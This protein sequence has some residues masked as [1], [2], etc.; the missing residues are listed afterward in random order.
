MNIT[1]RAIKDILNSLSIKENIFVIFGEDHVAISVFIKK[2][3]ELELISEKNLLEIIHN[4]II[5]VGFKCYYQHIDNQE[6]T[7]PNRVLS[8]Q[9]LAYILKNKEL[10]PK[11]KQHIKYSPMENE[12][13]F[14][15][16]Y[17]P[18][19]F[20]QELMD[21]LLIVRSKGCAELCPHSDTCY[22][23]NNC[24]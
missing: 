2:A 1:T 14:V 23:A 4:R 12:E 8:P 16:T 9:A 10:E 20:P 17:C 18:K 15:Q 5:R 13:V 21:Q 7:S 11:S 6:Y 24:C 22:S 19:N 3:L